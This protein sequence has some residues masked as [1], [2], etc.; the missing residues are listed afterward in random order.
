MNSA[1]AE[2]AVDSYEVAAVLEADG[3]TD[4][5]A[6]ERHGAEDVFDLADRLFRQ[7][8][9][10]PQPNVPAEGPWRAKPVTHVLRGV[11]F[12][13]PALAYLTVADRITGPRAAVLLVVSVLLSW[14]A[15]QGLAHLGHARL[16]RTGRNGAAAVLSGATLAVG[17]P[18]VAVV[19]ALGFALGVPAVVTLIAAGQLVYVL[20]ATV[21]LVLGREWWLLAALA[22]GPAA[23]L[24]AVVVAGWSVRGV[25]PERPARAEL[26]AALPAVAF[27]AVVGG[28]LIFT[29]AL[30]ALD[31]QPGAT[32]T[33]AVLLPLSVSMGAA[34]WLLYRYR[35]ATHHAMAV[36]RTFRVFR[37][38]ANAALLRASA[39]YVAVLA[40]LL[41]AG[42][43]LTGELPRA[44]PAL[45]G[46][47][48]FLALLLMSFGIR[49]PVVLACLAALVASLA[50]M[51][52]ASPETIQ[53][54]TAAG[55]LIALYAYAHLTLRRAQ[56]HL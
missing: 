42:A 7:T 29:A 36:S 9:R 14:S 12:G 50:L 31:P 52:F 45:I 30:R 37:R 41:A 48:L 16:S 15:G 22:A 53:A 19:A 38:R 25:R 2:A 1:H 21:A 23:P 43:V 35:A 39:T 13:L 26:A 3:V 8:P 18:A 6:R 51:P 46:P 27:G 20:A 40:V 28:L 49:G 5:T 17:V 44:E 10:Q 11:L 32:G 56:L 34:E 47:A 54:G 24:A 55:L 33:L 4:V